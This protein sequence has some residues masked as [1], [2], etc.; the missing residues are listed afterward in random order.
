MSRFRMIVVC[1]AL[2]LEGMSTS[3]INVQIGAVQA[4]L[5]LSPAELHL[6]PSAFLI[7]YAG[8]L[9]VAGALADRLDRRRVFLLGITL[10]G[11]GCL[12]CAAAPDAWALV[13]GRFVQGAGAALSAP[14]AL[15]IITAGL[16]EGAAR[17]RAVATYGAM[18]AVGFSLGLVLPGA[19]VTAFGWRW[20]FAASLP[21]VLLVLA[22]TWTVPSEP[23]RRD[24]GPDLR[25][26]AMLVAALM[27]AVHLLGAFSALPGAWLAVEAAV[28][29]ALVA[30]L[31]LRGGVRDL[32]RTV[33]GNARVRA[34]C[35]ALGGLFAGV[36]ASMYALSLAAHADGHDAIVVALL[37]V[38]QP[39]V[40]SLTATAG[41]RLVTS[42]GPVVPFVAGGLLFA[43]SIGW[44]AV[45]GLDSPVWLG[46]LPAMAGVG[47]ALGL[48][49]PAASVGAVDATPA[50]ARGTTAGVLTTAQNTGGALGIAALS[51]LAV[52][53]T[54]GSGIGV[55]PAM[56]WSCGLALAGLA[57]AALVLTAARRHATPA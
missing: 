7:A 53:P 54:A 21:A 47:A 9:P 6:V 28:L 10:F 15:A 2:L 25:G 46:V 24:A 38:P 41:A 39:V 4:D 14:A 5:A 33:V 31:V 16:P 18:G 22:A 44:L 17:N 3:G 8:L 26:A 55:E 48:C 11:V 19:L 23:A 49:F 36:V 45:V 29:A 30:R 32:P 40:F 43:A 57:A 1:L 13:A 27:I 35:L 56:A 34:A 37:V 51:A 20:S 12:V 50:H 52:V 42:R